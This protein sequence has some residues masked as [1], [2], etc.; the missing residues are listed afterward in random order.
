[1]KNKKLLLPALILVVALVAIGVYSVVS[2]I[3]QKPTVTQGEFPFSITYEL[4]GEQTTIREV[5]KAR[6]TGNGGYADTKSRVYVGEIGTRGEGET[7][8]VLKQQNNTRIELCTNFYA[9]YM[10]G[11]AEGDYF[12][13]EPFAPR[14]YYYDENETEYYD[15]ETLASQGVKLIDFEY[16]A[17]I[18]NSFVF[19]HISHFSSMVVFPAVLI[20]VLALGAILIF[21]KKEQDFQR[22]SIDSVSIVLNYI[23]GFAFVPFVTLAGMLL[24]INGGSS[25]FYVQ[26]FYFIPAFS[27]LCVAASVALRRKGC[28]VASLVSGLLG[29][30]IFGVCC[31]IGSLEGLM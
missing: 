10:M 15:E 16:P 30:G 13:E 9:D 18:A 2:S 22:K 17:P 5:Y 12:E 7:V 20:G 19:S 25:E 26:A 6:Y 21:V 14:I 4:D 1:M 23:V 28:G 11:D 8:Y 3:A 31:V 27:V 29:P 24:D